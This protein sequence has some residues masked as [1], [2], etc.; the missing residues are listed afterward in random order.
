MLNFPAIPSHDVLIL[1]VGFSKAMSKAIPLTDELGNAVVPLIRERSRLPL[2][3][4]F[5]RGQ[6]ESC[7][8]RLSD[9][10]PDLDAAANLANRLLFQLGSEALAAVLTDRVL[11]AREEV[12][13]SEW[14][15]DL[16]GIMHIRRSTAITFNQDTLLE[17]AA[18]A[19]R[20]SSWTGR[21][22]QSTLPEITWWDVL[23]GQPER[24]PSQWG[25]WRARTDVPPPQDARFDS[26][27][28]A[29]QRYERCDD[30]LMDTTGNRLSRPDGPRGDRRDS[31]MAPGSRAPHRLAHVW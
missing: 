28:L 27:V 11:H 4:R 12:I 29:V 19:G 30:R 6:F 13:G 23:N 22:P 9:E 1:G 14:I 16:L 2:P 15:R 17:I 3:R 10:Q 31:S 25:A 8:S 7:L 24:P 21:T 20:F 5:R 26:L 18:T